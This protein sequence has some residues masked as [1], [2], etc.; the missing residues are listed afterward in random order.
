MGKTDFC[1][2][3]P[4]RLGTAL[5]VLLR[6]AG[7]PLKGIC[8]RNLQSARKA[9]RAAGGGIA[10][11][12]P[13]RIASMS[14]L[15]LITTPDDAIAQICRQV[16][17]GKGFR[18]KSIVA[19]CSGALNSDILA[20][21]VAHGAHAGSIHPIQSFATPRDAVRLLPGSYCCIEGDKIAEKILNSMAEDLSLHTLHVPKDKKILY[22]AG[23]V[24][25]SNLMV[26][27]QDIA[28]QIERCA[29]LPDDNT[30][31]PFMPLLHGTLE[32]IEHLGTTQALTG[33]FARG[34]LET[35]RMHLHSLRQH[36][37]DALPAYVTLALRALELGVAQGKISREKA[38]SMRRLLRNEA[39]REECKENPPSLEQK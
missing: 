3:G 15:V 30:L 17:D 32:N 24:V 6:E 4:G 29:G 7:W 37:P 18:R 9:C 13:V 22:H 33:P 11:C 39:D 8:G 23:A 20:P 12:D 10:V 2:V 27:L 35:V 5:A 14:N 26:A 19:H 34:D 25:A 28:L 38:D 21:A 1:I 31:K 16:A 36:C